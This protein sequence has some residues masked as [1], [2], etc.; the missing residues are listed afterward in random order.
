MLLLEVLLVEVL[1]LG[2]LG[3]EVLLLVVLVVFKVQFPFILIVVEVVV[4]LEEE[5]EVCG[6]VL[7]FFSILFHSQCTH[8]LLS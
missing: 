4:E 3:V 2:V 6:Y 7:Y 8:F 1:L 5:G